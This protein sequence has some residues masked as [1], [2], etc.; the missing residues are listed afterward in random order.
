[1][2]LLKDKCCFTGRNRSVR[3]QDK[4]KHGSHPTKLS[5]W[6]DQE[7]YRKSLAEHNIDEKEVMLF[8]RI[9]LERHDY[10]ATRAE[11]LQTSNIGFFV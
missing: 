1:M 11:R 8:D 6:Y 5:I 10:A 9:A 4:S 2:V 3:K 7:E